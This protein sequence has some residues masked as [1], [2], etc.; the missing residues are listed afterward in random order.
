MC[1]KHQP[2]LQLCRSRLHC[3]PTQ[4]VTPPLSP[5]PLCR[6]LPAVPFPVSPCPPT[7]NQSTLPQHDD[8]I[9]DDS[10]HNVKSVTGDKFSNGCKITGT[11]FV[12][13]SRFDHWSSAWRRRRRWALPLQCSDLWCHR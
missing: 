9:D 5:L 13:A 7:C 10:Y 2:F 12:S 4:P 1:S 11:M 8:V 3:W 6:R